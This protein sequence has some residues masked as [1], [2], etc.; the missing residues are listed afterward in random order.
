M[1]KPLELLPEGSIILLDDAYEVV[2]HIL[3][4]LEQTRGGFLAHG[5]GNRLRWWKVSPYSLVKEEERSA[6]QRRPLRCCR[7]R[8]NAAAKRPRAA[9]C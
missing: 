6:S 4:S 7:V 2:A 3:Q 1:R 8:Q 5:R 9:A